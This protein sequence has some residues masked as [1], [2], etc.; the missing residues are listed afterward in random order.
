M[1]RILFESL[2]AKDIFDFSH[3]T[4]PQD[5]VVCETLEILPALKRDVFVHVHDIFTPRDYPAVWVKAPG[6]VLE[7]AVFGS[8]LF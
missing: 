1:D 3:V 4:R 5:D 8:R 6:A 7:R 2:E